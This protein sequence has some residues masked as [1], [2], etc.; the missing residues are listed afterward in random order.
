MVA[1]GVLLVG[2]SG[3]ATLPVR[4]L[5]EALLWCAAALTIKTGYDYLRAGL[6]HMQGDAPSLK[7]VKPSSAT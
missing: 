4:F 5:G 6:V 2:D 1:I 3:P 7:A